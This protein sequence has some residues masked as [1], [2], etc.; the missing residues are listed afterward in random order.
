MDRIQDIVKK[1]MIDGFLSVQGSHALLNMHAKAAD[2]MLTALEK[3][4][5]SK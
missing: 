5:A 2:Q 4:T 1:D 3:K